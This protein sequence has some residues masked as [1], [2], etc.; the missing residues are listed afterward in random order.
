MKP[1]RGGPGKGFTRQQCQQEALLP[2]GLRA[3]ELSKS[4]SLCVISLW[5]EICN[6]SSKKSFFFLPFKIG[7]GIMPITGKL[8]DSK[9]TEYLTET[10]GPL[11][12]LCFQNIGG[13]TL[14]LQTGDFKP[15]LTGES[16]QPRRNDSMIP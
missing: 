10:S 9:C 4:G 8:S 6:S 11:L 16:G 14:A 12:P 5:Q 7:M 1:K 15:L 2:L 3:L 13:Q